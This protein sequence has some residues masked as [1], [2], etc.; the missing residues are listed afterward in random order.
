MDRGRGST[1]GRSN[2]R[3]VPR[4]DRLTKRSRRHIGRSLRSLPRH[5]R[6]AGSSSRWTTTAADRDRA[7]STDGRAGIAMCAASRSTLDVRGRATGAAAQECHLTCMGREVGGRSNSTTGCRLSSTS[8]QRPSGSRAMASCWTR[9]PRSTSG[10]EPPSPTR[11]PLAEGTAPRSSRRCAAGRC[12]TRGGRRVSRSSAT[13]PIGGGSRLTSAPWPS[14]SGRRRS[15]RASA[16]SPA[17][18]RTTSTTS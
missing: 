2:L 12:L 18:C 4:R 10:A 16:C 9:T 13:S 8:R 1:A 14:A 5:R 11:G 17:A 15:S 6:A 3:T 7:E